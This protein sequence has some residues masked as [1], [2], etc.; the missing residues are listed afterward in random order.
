MHPRLIVLCLALYHKAI[1]VA[2]WY[3]AY[4]A[5]APLVSGYKPWSHVLFFGLLGG[6]THCL[7]ALY[8]QYCVKDEWDSRWV[9]WHFVRP[10]V[11]AIMGVFSLISVKVGLLVLVVS[12]EKLDDRLYGIYAL[13]FIAGYN[14]DYFQSQIRRVTENVKNSSARKTTMD[15]KGGDS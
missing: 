3:F 6:C 11:S 12:E 9:V 7:R 10:C 1:I 4:V 14:V 5:N 15:D 2:A 8:V 13:A